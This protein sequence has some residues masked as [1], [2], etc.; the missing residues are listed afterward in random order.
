MSSTPKGAGLAR[1]AT[2]NINR[3]EVVDRN[4]VEFVKGWTAAPV[5]RPGPQEPIRPGAALSVQEF[6]ELFDS[7]LANRHL[8]LE[9]RAMRARG[10]GFYTI[11]SSGH[12]G[13]ALVGRFTRH[14]WSSSSRRR[15]APCGVM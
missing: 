6:L 9:A 1:G 5:R 7:Q 12:E 15:C 10:E 13:N 2:R 4:F 3:A 14:S 8:D 11:G